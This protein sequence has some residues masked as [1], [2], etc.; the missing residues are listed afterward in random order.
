MNNKLWQ[1]WQYLL[2]LPRCIHLNRIHAPF[3]FELYHHLFKEKENYY[4]FEEIE[5]IR[6]KL[7]LTN[8]KLIVDDLGAGSSVHKSNKRHIRDI[9]ETSLKPA[10]TAQLLFRFIDHFKPNNVVELGTCL[11]ITS[12]YLGR[13]NPKGQVT[14]LEGSSQLAKVAKINFSKLDLK[15]I[16]QVEGNFDE[17]LKATLANLKIVDFMFFDGNHRKEP[18][19]RYFEKALLHS[20]EHAIFVFDDIYW[21]KD[22]TE[23]WRVIKNHP[24]VTVTIDCYAMGFVFFKKDQ[25]KEHFTVYH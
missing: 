15:N 5:S 9:A 13:A 16:T 8:K 1:I 17:T 3:V 14:T 4:A 22:M 6:A 19:L 20:N 18:T 10:K 2:Y 12:A 25:A 7:L 11:G 21:S 23:A 24:S